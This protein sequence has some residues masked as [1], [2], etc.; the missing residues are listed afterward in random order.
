MARKLI[1]ALGVD[2]EYWTGEGAT[3]E[4]ATSAALG[5]RDADIGMWYPERTG[6]DGEWDLFL[7]VI[8]AAGGAVAYR[9][10]V[11]RA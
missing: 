3:V 7:R 5:A 8:R 6:P 2:D 11:R 9:A 4:L 10:Y 1:A